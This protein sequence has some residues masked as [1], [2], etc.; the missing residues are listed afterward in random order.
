MVGGKLYTARTA[1]WS[2]GV[3][4]LCV[5]GNGAT[6]RC[7]PVDRGFDFIA[8]TP[9]S[10]IRA[11]E[12]GAP[13]GPVASYEIVTARAGSMSVQT[14]DPGRRRQLRRG[15]RGLSDGRRDTFR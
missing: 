2:C 10:A 5:D 11:G 15:K 13:H 12:V 1:Y 7:I 8:L 14:S 3:K 9:A 4:S 6:S